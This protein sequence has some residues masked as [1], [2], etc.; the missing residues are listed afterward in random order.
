MRTEFGLFLETLRGKLSLREAAEKSGLSHAYIRDLELG[1]NR[2]T[3]SPINPTPETIRRLAEAYNYD[4]EELM[5]KAGYLEYG[6]DYITNDQARNDAIDAYNRLP[7]NKKKLVDD[8][9]KA[10][11]DD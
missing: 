4:Y 11:S 8:M 1:K 5:Q 3:K 9:I 6:S 2:K 10:L 7:P